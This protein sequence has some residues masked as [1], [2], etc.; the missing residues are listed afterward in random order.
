MARDPAEGHGRG[1]RGA[2]AGCACGLSLGKDRSRHG[3]PPR[4]RRRR[5]REGRG[6]AACCEDDSEPTPRARPQ[7]HAVRE[8]GQA[9]ATEIQALART[10]DRCLLCW[11]ASF[12][13]P[14]A[15]GARGKGLLPPRRPTWI[16][17]RAHVL[18]MPG[19]SSFSQHATRLPPP[20]TA[21][22]IPSSRT[23]HPRSANADWGLV[24]AA[25]HRRCVAL[26]GVTAR[27]PVVS[28]ASMAPEATMD[29]LGAWRVVVQPLGRRSG[30]CRPGVTRPHRRD[31]SA[32]REPR[33]AWLSRGWF[34]QRKGQ[35][36]TYARPRHISHGRGGAGARGG[37]PGASSE[38][39]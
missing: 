16:L 6:A 19:I 23:Q 39:S 13:R 36:Q 20:Q 3:C 34:P 5:P 22:R 18:G 30:L 1:R 10:S 15:Q 4:E 8:T 26:H 24:G 29:A 7:V 35:G 32:V 31:P 17:Q 27:L 11:K 9:H 2:S 37:A 38:R 21:L 14:R 25:T 28:L 12:E 33:P